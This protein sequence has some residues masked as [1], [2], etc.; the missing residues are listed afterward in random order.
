SASL[1]TF[2]SL[3]EV[4]RENKYCRPEIAEGGELAI[5][6]GRHPVVEA[7]SRERF[8]PNDC[9]LDDGENRTMILTGPNMAGKST[10]LRQVALIVLMAHIGSFVPA[11]SARVPLCD[12]IFTR[13]GASDNLILDRSTFMVEM[14]EVATI[15]RSATKNSLLI[16]DEVGRG[17]STYDG[18]SIAWSVIEHLTNEVRAKTLFA[19]HYHELTELE[20]KLN[21]VKNYKINVREIGGSIVFLRKI[22]RG[23]ANKSFGIEVAALAG[24]PAAVTSRAKTL[25]KSLEKNDL[26]LKGREVPEE[27]DYEAECSAIEEELKGIDVN[28]LTPMQALQLLSEWKSKL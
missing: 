15:L 25:L 27:E 10:Y 22:V 24:V 7:I 14:T 5:K 11:A 8:V 23:G 9:T 4:A 2:L 26:A 17:T 21:G 1:D 18:L 12:R 3:A 13:I 20:G 19:T 16:L 6:D 28:T